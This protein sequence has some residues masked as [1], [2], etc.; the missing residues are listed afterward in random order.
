MLVALAVL[1]TAWY[2]A[3]QM[4]T[5]DMAEF[6]D[7]VKKDGDGINENAAKLTYYLTATDGAGKVMERSGLVNE[8]LI[9]RY[10]EMWTDIQAKI[11]GVSEAGIKFNQGDH[12]LLI[13]GLFPPPANDQVLTAN[14]GREFVENDIQFHKKL[15]ADMKAGEPAKSEDVAKL[16][17]ERRSAEEARVRAELG[18]DLNAQEQA[19]LTEELVAMRVNALRRR[20]GEI[21]VFADMTIFDGLPASVPEQAPSPSLAWFMQ[22]RAW[23]DQDICRAVSLAN[24]ASSSGV[25]DAPVK[26]IVKIKS[27]WDAGSDRAPQPSAYEPGDDKPP[28]NF[29]ISITGRSSGP[30]SRNR[31][32]DVRPVTIEAV[33]SSQKLPQF[34][35][36]LTATNF[37]SLLD[38]DLARV[39]PLTDLR[40]GFSYGDEHVVR[41]TIVLETIWLR[42]W[43]KPAMPPDV[44]AA[45]GMVENVDG[46]AAVA[47]PAAA[48][49]PAGRNP[50]IN[51]PGASRPTAPTARPPR[52]G[53]GDSPDDRGG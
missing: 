8:A 6:Q 25:A 38:L 41:A 50:R 44:K 28:L 48:P 29:N 26:R 30:G 31:W 13:D 32:Y 27:S 23:I 20:A 11:G 39:E 37:M 14:K 52:R 36:A 43:R 47:A 40:E 12:K 46:A 49:A 17:G 10:G 53:A 15:L 9:K 51:T 34:L 33:V 21:A 2:F 18:R 1:P 5:K 42:E 16:L 22:E 7:R 24:A 19:K 4:R 45:L 35:N 3:E